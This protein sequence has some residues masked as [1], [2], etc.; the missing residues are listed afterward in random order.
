MKS[1]AQNEPLKRDIAALNRQVLELLARYGSN[2]PEDVCLQLNI[3][4]S[5]MRAVLELSNA[6]LVEIA[7]LGQFLFQ[8][9]IE[10]NVLSVCAKLNPEQAKAHMRSATRLKRQ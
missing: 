6:Q 3:S 10:P 8:P 2:S 9:V 1:S 5:F 7:N 4:Q